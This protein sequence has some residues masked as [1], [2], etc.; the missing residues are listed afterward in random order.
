MVRIRCLVFI[1][2][3]QTIVHLPHSIQLFIILNASFSFPL[4]RKSSTFLMLIPENSA[5][6]QLALHEPQEMHRKASGSIW[7]SCLN[8]V[9]SIVSRFIVEL[10]DILNPKLFIALIPQI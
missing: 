7:H 8:L 1:P 4:C 9:R 5:A 6:G 10:W 2:L 3:G